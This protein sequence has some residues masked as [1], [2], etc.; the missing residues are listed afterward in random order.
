MLSETICVIK[1]RVYGEKFDSIDQ[2]KAAIT[3][4]V[5]VVHNDSDLLQRVCLSVTKRVAEC[6][7][8]DG[9]HFEKNR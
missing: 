6:V 9:G 5:S 3:R 1:D 2:L 8:V 4:E 7:E